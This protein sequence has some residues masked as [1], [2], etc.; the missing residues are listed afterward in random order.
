MEWKNAIVRA[1][2]GFR[3][4]RGLYVVATSSLAVAFLCLGGAL[5]AVENLGALADRWGGTGRVTVYLADDARSQDVAQLK[6]VLESLDEVSHVDEVTPAEARAELL[7]E[8]DD[9]REL[10][11]LPANLLPA[12]VEIELREN[13]SEARVASIA[14]RVSQFRGVD[15][16]DT[17]RGFF[18]RLESLT[19]TGRFVALAVAF[20][21][22]LCV[23]AVVGNTIRLS[24]ARRQREI[25]VQKLCGATDA[26]VRRPFVVEGVMQA[27]VASFAAVTLLALGFVAVRSQVDAT[28]TGLLGTRLVFLSPGLLVAMLVSGALLGGLGSFLSVRRYLAV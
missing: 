13:V 17:Y 28:I 23:L 9:E 12:S 5:L 27:F 20:L 3:D 8:F 11:S 1:R 7:A 16:V 21:V 18:A 6:M 19:S 10:A 22:A 4:E 15:S 24:V 25:E 26:F 14:A 2:R